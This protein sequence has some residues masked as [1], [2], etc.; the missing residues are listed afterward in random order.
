MNK[1][2]VF[3]EELNFISDEKIR[4]FAETAI[5]KL[6]DYFFDVAA[7]STGKYHPQYSLGIGGLV[8]HTKAAVKL[9]N[10]VLALEHYNIFTKDEKDMIITS[11]IL[12]DGWKHGVL[13]NTYTV[14]KHPI[15]ASEWVLQDPDF[16][17]ITEEQK[18]F[19]SDCIA[20]HMGEWNVD[21]KTNEEIL[22]KPQTEAQKFVHLCDYLASRKYITIEFDNY[23]NPENYKD[24]ST[25]VS[26]EDI[27]ALCKQNIRRCFKRII[28]SNYS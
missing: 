15:I 23:Y 3:E 14:A 22:P 21:W 1:V 8:R 28:V 18:K 4:T 6:P 17:M 11:L 20:S 9:A 10:E 2:K 24:N 19:I 16:N 26:K 12:H 25:K 27:I 13:F 7:S 5:S